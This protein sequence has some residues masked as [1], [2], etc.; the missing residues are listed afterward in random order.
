MRAM[1]DLLAESGGSLVAT[2]TPG[3][4]TRLVATVPLEGGP[5]RRLVPAGGTR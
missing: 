5:V 4:G 2:S 3:S 1:E